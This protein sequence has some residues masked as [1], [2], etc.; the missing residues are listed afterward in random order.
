[1]TRSLRLSICFVAPGRDLRPGTSYTR[2]VLSLARA[3]AE[4][5]DVT[6]VFRRL[7]GA[8]GNERFEVCALE[9]GTEARPDAAPSRR[10][11]QLA[12]RGSGV[13]GVILE[14]S[15]PSAGRLTAWCARRGVPAIPVIDHLPGTSWLA[16][17]DAGRDWLALGSSG[18][19]LRRVPEV[20]A[21]TDALR[22]AIVSRWRVQAD[23]VAV[24]GP[25]VDRALFAPRDQAEARRLLGLAANHRIIVAGDGLGSGPDL[26]PLI[27]AVQRAG[28]STLRLHILGDGGRRA[29]LE[30]LAGSGG[31]V[32]FHGQVPDDLVAAYIGAADLCVSVDERGDSAFTVRECLSAGRP[33]AIGADRSH[34]LVRHLVS[35]F[36][37][38][39]DLLAWIRFIQRDCPSRNTLRFMGV[40][41]TATPLEGVDQT[42]AAY[43]ET[44]E[45]VRRNAPRPAVAR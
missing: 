36:R 9:D 42:A 14:G 12:E 27:E 1:M 44:V 37:V 13:F 21:G 31:A 45:R 5:A 20:V 3:L 6:V 8:V 28:D 32:T 29:A 40:A 43:L 2:H 39:H 15:W 23:R 25:G 18:R 41:A 30:R 10:L 26:T 33:V 11:G 24:I 17:L 35:G 22:T 34:P 19:Y 16:P 4:A 7:S 38:D